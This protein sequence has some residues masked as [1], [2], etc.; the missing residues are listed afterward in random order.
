LASAKQCPTC[1]RYGIHGSNAE[2][3][4]KPFVYNGVVDTPK[5]TFD[6]RSTTVALNP[7]L[8]AQD[9]VMNLAHQRGCDWR[10]SHRSA[11]ALITFACF[12]ITRFAVATTTRLPASPVKS[13]GTGFCGV[14]GVWGNPYF[15]MIVLSTWLLD[16]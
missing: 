10:L 1:D 3:V 16:Y 11:S 14:R 12:L 13:I 15:F 2:N 5:R 4:I 8:A 6:F 7:C 9:F